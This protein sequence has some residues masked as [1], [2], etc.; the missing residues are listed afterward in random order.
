MEDFGGIFRGKIRQNK[1]N[2]KEYVQK[3]IKLQHF[4]I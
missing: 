1:D 2:T 3:N 4:A